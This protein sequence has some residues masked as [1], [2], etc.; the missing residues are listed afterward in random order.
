MNSQ[1]FAAYYLKNDRVVAVAA[2]NRMNLIQLTNEAL[3]LNV[4]PSGTEVREGKAS[5]QDLRS[6]I[7][8][9]KPRCNKAN[10]CRNK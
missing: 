2:M 1:N 10:C 5:L 6:R 9:K 3:R 4:M 8:A 7:A